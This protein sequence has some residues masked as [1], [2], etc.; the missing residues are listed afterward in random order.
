MANVLLVLH[1]VVAVTMVVIILLQ[2]SEGGALGMGGGGGGFVSG[3]G[4]ANVMT[5]TTA[6]LAAIFFLTSIT[7]GI[8]GQ[9]KTPT[10]A[11]GTPTSTSAPTTAPSQAPADAPA[12]PKLN[13][14]KPAAPAQQ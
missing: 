11:I 10:S 2:R 4:A 3:R 9:R 8:L 7:L 5:R 14:P 6:I 12:L 13:I 1:I